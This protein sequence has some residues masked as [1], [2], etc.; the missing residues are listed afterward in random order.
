MTTGKFIAYYRVSTDRQGRSGLGLDAQKRAVAEYLNGG[1]WELVSEF[2]EV[3]SGKQNHRPELMAALKA[4][5]KQKA[6]LVIAKLDRLSRNLAFLANLM[7]AGVDFVATDMP[8]ANRTMLQMMAVFAEHERRMISQRTK[9]ALQSAKARGVRL[10]SPDPAK[11]AKAGHKTI[12]A[13]AQR[14]AENVLPIIW[15]MQ[16]AGVETLE[17]IAHAL[18]VRGIQTAR[19]G[20]WY[21]TTVRNL[22][23]RQG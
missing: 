18:N 17:G 5:K 14:F 19:G 9:D 4:C 12:K 6:T 3:E 13:N 8:E 22:L 16:K 10:G 2:T 11:A 20:Q 21:P 7:E 23:A 1:S 15:E